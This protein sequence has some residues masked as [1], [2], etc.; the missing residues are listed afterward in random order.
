MAI[1]L[2]ARSVHDVLDAKPVAAAEIVERQ[3]SARL[4]R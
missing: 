1:E 3:A 4:A 2:V